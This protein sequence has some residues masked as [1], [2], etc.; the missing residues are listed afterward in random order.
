MEKFDKNVIKFKL[1][2]NIHDDES[3]GHGWDS[4]FC[5]PQ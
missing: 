5:W 3:S 2:Q 1:A 4:R